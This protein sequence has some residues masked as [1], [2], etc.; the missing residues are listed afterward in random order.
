MSGT[1]TCVVDDKT[2]EIYEKALA[3]HG[4]KKQKNIT[5]TC[6]NF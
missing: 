4:K 3:N 5:I 6:F 2:R 1:E